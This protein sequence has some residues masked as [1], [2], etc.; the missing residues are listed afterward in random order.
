MCAHALWRALN[1]YYHLLYCEIIHIELIL[2]AHNPFS[3]FTTAEFVD[4]R[5]GTVL[6]KNRNRTVLHTRFGTR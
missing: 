1:M 5:G 6:V 4:I 2:Q 3:L